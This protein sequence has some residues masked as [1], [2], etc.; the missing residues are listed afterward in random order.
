MLKFE[1]ALNHFP[2]SSKEKQKVASSK[3]SYETNDFKKV[4]ISNIESVEPLHKLSCEFK[5]SPSTIQG[6]VKKKDLIINVPDSRKHSKFSPRYD[7]R[8]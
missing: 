5:I 7:L 4:V 3:R 1:F 6:W 8:L 2:M